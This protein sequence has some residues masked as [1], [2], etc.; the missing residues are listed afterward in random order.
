MFEPHSVKLPMNKGEGPSEPVF[1]R[2]RSLS[3]QIAF[4]SKNGSVILRHLNFD[5]LVVVKGQ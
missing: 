1:S 4:F 2:C 5:A 3:I